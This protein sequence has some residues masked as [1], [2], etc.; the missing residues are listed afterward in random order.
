[1][2]DIIKTAEELDEISAAWGVGTAAGE[3]IS[4]LVATV[5][6]L[7]VERDRFIGEPLCR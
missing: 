5:E 2:T 3:E 7:W 1:M 4:R 6:A